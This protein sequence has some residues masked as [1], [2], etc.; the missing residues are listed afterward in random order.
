MRK[1]PQV[2]P[3]EARPSGGIYTFLYNRTGMRI[4]LKKYKIVDA[5]F[6]VS[7]C[8]VWNK[9]IFKL[10]YFCFQLPTV[11][12]DFLGKIL[13]ILT[14]KK[15]TINHELTRINTKKYQ[16]IKS[17]SKLHSKRNAFSAQKRSLLGVDEKKSFFGN[18]TINIWAARNAVR[19]RKTE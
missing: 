9:K 7:P 1:R 11:L 16:I 19:S 15:T 8:L 14:P 6:A 17:F 4:W 12:I 10:F 2:V 18:F 13:P 3:T 5:I